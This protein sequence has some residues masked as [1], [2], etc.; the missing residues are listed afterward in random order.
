MSKKILLIMN[1]VAGTKRPNKDLTEII[2]Y[3]CQNDC[4]VQVQMTLPNVGA[5]ELV[6][7]HGKNADT[8][9]CIG[10]DG[11]FNEMISG[12]VEK[13]IDVPVGYIPSGSTNDFAKGLGISHVPLTAAK[14]I[15]EG[16]ARYIDAGF[17]NNRVFIYTAS[18]GIFTKTSYNT[19]R[20]LK[21][22]LGYFAYV[23]EG[24]KEFVDIPRY[25][26]KA[27]GDNKT[28]EDDYIFGAVCNSKRIGGGLLKFEEGT[29]DMND[30]LLEVLFIKYPKNPAEIPKIMFDA[31]NAKF[32]SNM[33]DFFS[34]N[35][36][37][38][39]TEDEIIWTLDGEYQ[40]GREK[41]VIRNI[42]SAV[43]LILKDGKH[44]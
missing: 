38:I 2:S 21:N 24:T 20:D 43:P 30:G 23:L 33:F 26:I 11:T 5:D 6:V 40:K 19:S 31:S 42:K 32:D 29:V 7:K 13:N 1:P 36:L 18:F 16:K 34:T 3:F 14:H 10:G 4:E 25:H 27:V 35:E 28:I 39:Y 44:K 22:M 12:I 41:T 9:V 17:F 8:I 15:I 37:T